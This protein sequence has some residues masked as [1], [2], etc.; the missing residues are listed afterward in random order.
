[1]MEASVSCWK[2][3]LPNMSNIRISK[4][5]VC[6]CVFEKIAKFFPSLMKT[7]KPQIQEMQLK[8]NTSNMKKVTL[9]HIFKFLK[10]S[11]KWQ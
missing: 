11:D 1:M 3:L 7:I 6:V 2:D 4:E 8:S 10:I 5:G 9:K